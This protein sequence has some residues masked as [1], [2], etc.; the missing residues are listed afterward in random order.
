MSSVKFDF[1]PTPQP[2]YAPILPTKRKETSSQ[3]FLGFNGDSPRLVAA[4]GLSQVN[5]DV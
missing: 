1:G 3:S 4:P 2:K 5:F